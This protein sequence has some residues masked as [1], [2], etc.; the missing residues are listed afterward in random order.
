MIKKRALDFSLF[1]PKNVLKNVIIKIYF[2]VRHYLRG[3]NILKPNTKE[4]MNA[5]KS[6]WVKKNTNSIH[7]KMKKT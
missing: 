7:K 3:Y 5:D 2:H 1:L 4:K 6:L